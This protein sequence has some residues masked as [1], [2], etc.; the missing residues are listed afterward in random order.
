MGT[1][2]ADEG[3]DGVG[4]LECPEHDG[5][6]G[7]GDAVA[8]DGVVVAGVGA[9]E[10][11]GHGFGATEK[12]GVVGELVFEGG[13]IFRVKGEGADEAGHVVDRVFTEREDAVAYEV[14]AVGGLAGFV[15]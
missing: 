1:A 14:T 11:D 12:V 5:E 9:G 2:F 10:F 6:H 15:G 7:G 8:H 13:E 3:D 4:G